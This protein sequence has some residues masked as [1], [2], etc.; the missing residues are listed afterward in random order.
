MLKANKVSIKH[1]WMAANKYE[2]FRANERHKHEENLL[3]YE[4]TLKEMEF[5]LN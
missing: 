3:I 2:N 4:D 1:T 5:L